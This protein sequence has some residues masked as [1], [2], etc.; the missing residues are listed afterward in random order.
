MELSGFPAPFSMQG[1]SL[2]PILT[3]KAPVN[4]HKDSVYSEFYY[5]LKGTH[6]DIYATMYFD[7][8]YKIVNYHG[9]EFGELYDLQSDPNE[10]ENLW[11]VPEYEKLKAELTKKNFDSAI[12]KNMD[13]SMNRIN[14]Y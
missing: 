11:D 3:G 12:M 10:F 6:E 14:E 9:K 4:Y 5:C 7:G 1:K 8:R 13:Y 2:A